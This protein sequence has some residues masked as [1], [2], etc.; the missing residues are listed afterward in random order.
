MIEDDFQSSEGAESVG[1]SGDDS[2]LVVESLD[3]AAGKFPFGEEPIE[4]EWLVG[5]EYAGDLLHGF[6]AAAHRALTLGVQEVP[7]AVVGAVGPEVLEGLLEQGG[8]GG[9]LL[10]GDQGVE[11]LA[12][13]ATDSAALLEQGPAHAL[14]QT[15]SGVASLAQASHLASA[16]FVHGAVEMGDDVETVQDVKGVSDAFPDHLQV[17]LPHVAA[18][19]LQAGDH[20]GTQGIQTGLRGSRR[21]R[22][23]IGRDLQSIPLEVTHAIRRVQQ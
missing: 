17:G 12:G 14:Q 4:D 19:K 23:S 18:D 1:A 2:D 9:G 21:D 6:D 5:A 20:F 8:S 7:C 16:Y 11:T 22:T 13:V 3:G 10:A 15:E